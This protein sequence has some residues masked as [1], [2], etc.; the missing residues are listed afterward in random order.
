MTNAAFA[1]R[2]RAAPTQRAPAAAARAARLR[3][4]SFC[5][6]AAASWRAVSL[7]LSFLALR[8]RRASALEARSR[9]R[10][11]AADEASERVFKPRAAGVGRVGSCW[12]CCLRARR[13]RS[14]TRRESRPRILTWCG[15][16][17]THRGQ[18]AATRGAV[19]PQ[20]VWSA[21]VLPRVRMD[22]C[23]A[24]CS[25]STARC[26]PVVHFCRVGFRIITPRRRLILCGAARGRCRGGSAQQKAQASLSPPRHVTP[27]RH[28]R[29]PAFGWRPRGAPRRAR[30]SA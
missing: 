10:S 2:K 21:Q 13:C 27:C 23:A 24:V 15:R 17:F 16:G 30:A 26:R 5:T 12:G 6:A 11:V 18:G 28:A 7:A 14:P 3:A 29:A 20:G 19:G 4:S 8:S 1:A 22:L 25:A 9:C